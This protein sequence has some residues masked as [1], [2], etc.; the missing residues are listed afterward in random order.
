MRH[1]ILLFAFSILEMLILKYWISLKT[2]WQL[3]WHKLSSIHI[4]DLKTEHK[5]Q[6]KSVK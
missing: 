5:T 4:P 6:Y 3:S 2:S 1:I